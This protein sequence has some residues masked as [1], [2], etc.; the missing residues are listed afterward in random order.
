MQT[1]QQGKKEEG[2]E[3]RRGRRKKGKKE[4][5]QAYNSPVPFPQRLQKARIEEQF[6]KFLNMF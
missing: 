1:R 4:E 5:V 2:E 3:G 6:S